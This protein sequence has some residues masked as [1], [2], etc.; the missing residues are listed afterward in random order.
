[1]KSEPGPFEFFELQ[2]RTIITKLR[3]LIIN[4]V[5]DI[6]VDN[7]C[8]LKVHSQ[9][10]FPMSSFFLFDWAGLSDIETSRQFIASTLEWSLRI[11]IL[12]SIGC[13]LVSNTSSA[14]DSLLLGYAWPL[15][16]NESI[17]VVW[18]RQYRS[19]TLFSL[20][21]PQRRIWFLWSVSDNQKVDF[22]FGLMGI[23]SD[24]WSVARINC[25]PARC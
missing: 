23:D 10:N 18:E 16:R 25:R 4:E 21:V 19:L 1:M 17:T 8:F 3:E 14:S 6:P 7:L 12:S 20:R 11:N 15:R 5:Q 13:W 24:G 22:E 9:L 2:M